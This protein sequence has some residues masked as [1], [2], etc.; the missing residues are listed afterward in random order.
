MRIRALD[1]DD[2][3]ELH[4]AYAT[5]KRAETAGRPDAPFLTELEYRV[6]HRRPDPM[7][8]G[9]SF[10]V[11]DCAAIV[12]TGWLALPLADNTDLARLQ[13][14]VP[15][16]HRR[17]GVGSALLDR[18]VEEARTAGRRRLLANVWLPFDRREQH[19]YRRFA[20]R[21]GFTLANVEV[22]RDL[23]LPVADAVLD[24]LGAEGA[25]QHRGYELRT[26]TDDMPDD[27]VRTYCVLNNMLLSQSPTGDIDYEAENLTP[28]TYRAQQDQ[29]RL[30]G[31]IVYTT[32][33][34]DASGVAAAYSKLSVTPDEPGVVHQWGTLVHPDHRG[35]RLGIAVKVRSLQ[36]LQRRHP[37]RTRVITCNTES[38]AHMVAINER[39]GFRPVEIE[40][41]FQRRLG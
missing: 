5:S 15:P 17:R 21:H 23:A 34:L 28:E 3:A 24:D 10:A 26:F 7:Q 40:A 31:R 33:A 32:L 30:S 27:V 38:N 19:P 20:E 14:T 13:V 41:A 4:T 9:T 11:F 16:E 25:G 8:R 22:R 37:D 6:W 36:V 39:L 2:D 29:H 35:R 12:G 18:L 1:V